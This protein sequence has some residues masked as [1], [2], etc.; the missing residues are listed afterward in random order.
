MKT[1]INQ[2]ILM[3]SFWLCVERSQAS[4]I[5]VNISSNITDDLRTWTSGTNYPFGGFTT[6]LAGV[7]FYFS[8][9]PGITN[10]LGVVYTGNGTVS[11]PITNNFPVNVTNAVTVFT[12]MNSSWGEPGYTNG[13]IAFYGSQGAYVSFNIVQGINIRDH[14]ISGYTQ[15]VSSNIMSIYWGPAN[16]CRNDSQGWMLPTNFLS[17]V[18]T[19]IQIRSFGNNPDGVATVA[20]IT[21][22]TNGPNITINKNGGQA[23]CY[24]PSTPTNFILQ[25]ASSLQNPNWQVANPP[26][27]TNNQFAAKNSLGN[28]QQF[29]RLISVP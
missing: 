4:D 15:I 13:K 18:L 1:L 10:G 14:R 6:N 12:L 17:Q 24:W 16:I 28:G 3:V 19:N 2:I 23:I 29:Y 11:A 26:F 8:P 20:A 9:F 21:I 7:S 22:R 5:N 25:T 27:V